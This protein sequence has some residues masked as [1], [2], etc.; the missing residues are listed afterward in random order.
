MSHST[1]RAARRTVVVAGVLAT[2]LT[3]ASCANSTAPASTDAGSDDVTLRIAFS[4]LPEMVD[5]LADAFH[6]EHPNIT[7]SPE[8]TAFA[9]YVTSIRLSMSSDTAPDIAQFAVPSKDLVGAGEQL[10]LDDYAE[11]QGWYDTFPVS[12]LEQL[13]LSDDGKEFGAGSLYGVPVALSMVGVFYNKQIAEDIGMTE[14][15]TSIEEFESALDKAK[16]AGETPIMMGALDYGANHVWGALTNSF[17]PAADY[18]DWVNGAPGGDITGDESLAASTTFAEWADKG[19]FNDGANGI[20][21]ADA[22]ATFSAGDGLFFIGGNWVT[23]ALDEAMGDNVGY[24]LFPQSEEDKPAVTGGS[25]VAYTVSARTEHPDEVATFLNWLSTPEAGAI[26]V[27]NGYLPVA[28]EALTDATGVAS[29]VSA[30]YD[31]ITAAEGV[32]LFSDWSATDQL[33]TLTPGVQG[34]VAGETDPET[35]LES[36]QEVRDAYHEE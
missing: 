30:A 4:S 20:G 12:A 31:D 5:A 33:A 34:M 15:P 10:P 32:N 22:S 17:M 35:F 29:E 23:G 1:R 36:I 11:E 16:D 6:E 18:R 3:A 26:V 27:D 28:S 21:A 24:F 9:D 8:Y 7:I 13:E 19:Y 14:M 2:A 25:S